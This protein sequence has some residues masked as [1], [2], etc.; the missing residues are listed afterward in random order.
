MSLPAPEVQGTGHVNRQLHKKSLRA[1]SWLL[2]K[3]I[4]FEATE[5]VAEPMD[6]DVDQRPEVVN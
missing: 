6:I 2:K 1:Q 4:W 5:P 3:S